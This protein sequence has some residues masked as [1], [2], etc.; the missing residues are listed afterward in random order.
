MIEKEFKDSQYANYVKGKLEDSYNALFHLMQIEDMESLAME[1]FHKA[2][3]ILWVLHE[4]G[5]YDDL[6]RKEKYSYL[7]KEYIRKI[8]TYKF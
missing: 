4:L 8:G 2:S 1:R 3:E 7:S 6:E 5:I